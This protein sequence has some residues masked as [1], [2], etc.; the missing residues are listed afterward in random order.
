M[1]GK[2][3]IF[4]CELGNGLR[5]ADRILPVAAG[6]V[7]AGH[8]VSVAL[9]QGA[10]AAHLITAAGHPVLTGPSWRAEAPPGFLAANFADVLI[11]TGY[12]T[13][14]ALA[15]LLS[16]WLTLLRA[17]APALVIADFAPTAMLACR[18]AGIPVAAMGDGY[19]LP[20]AVAPLPTMRPWAE[21]PAGTLAETDGR[22]IAVINP[23]LRALGARPI[24]RMADL[25]AAEA[26]WLCTFPELD[27]YEGRG[28]A[29]YFGEVPP[30]GT[31]MAV[32]WPAGTAERVLVMMDSRHRP[33]RPLLR[34]LVHLGL[35]AV[36]QAWGMTPE[37]A[38][39]LSGPT[40]RVV[41]EPVNRDAMLAHCDI[42]ACQGS[43]VVAPALLAGRPV[44]ML[45]N[46]VEQMMTLYRV[47]R[48][49]YGQ[50]VA[51]EA[52]MDIAG[53]ALR[54]LLDD[55]DCRLRAANFARSY[56]GYTPATATDTIIEECLDLLDPSRD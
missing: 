28:E 15:E 53:A 47:A 29:D 4:A 9:P 49:G 2:H 33:F 31:G 3:V 11:Q 22:V 35:P 19:S 40:I 34:A 7:A 30:P 32:E 13:P 41:T 43:G 27:H 38:A 56:H 55:P 1:A 21:L 16:G 26:T 42:V 20:P 51:P 5:Q 52:D 50:G 37:L 14:E 12:A 46:P 23:T 10:P 25:F 44:L 39:E 8:S 36:V 6:L 18:V 48:Q 17:E 45:P 54:R 24:S